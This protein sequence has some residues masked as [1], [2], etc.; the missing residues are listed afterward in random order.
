MT[1]SSSIDFDAVHAV[2][3]DMLKAVADLCEKYNIRYTLYCGTLLGAVRHGGFIPW[4]DDVDLAMPLKDYRR[5]QAVA[6]ELP[7]RFICSHLDNRN[8]HYCLWTRV[9]AEG[10]TA[11]SAEEARIPDMH[12]GLFLDI[13]PFI[14]AFRTTW[15]IR[16]QSTLLLFAQ[17]FRRVVYYRA[18]NDGGAVKSFLYHVPFFIRK[19][20]S[21]ALLK[22]SMRDP[23][24]CER[25]GTIDAAPFDGKF[26][27]KD[28][29]EMTTHRFEDR[30][31]RIPVQYDKILRRIYGDYMQLPPVE[32]RQGHAFVREQGKRIIDPYKD[33]RDYQREILGQ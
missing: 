12:W 28:W 17:R 13:Y 11:M 9:T 1:E 5:F 4:D 7:D 27:Q 16:L 18:C 6:R 20:I 31:F 22:M 2:E 21:D 33:Y 30:E 25:I 24:K 3:L 14:G 10:T 19:A 26:L 15:G 32:C 8:N 29:Q 23:E